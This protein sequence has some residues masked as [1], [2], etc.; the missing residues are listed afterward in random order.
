[1]RWEE[2]Q[3]EGEVGRGEDRQSFDKDVGGGLVAGQVRVELV[4]KDG[5][6]CVSVYSQEIEDAL[7]HEFLLSRENVR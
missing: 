1:M 6:Y 2:V 7:M 4:S 5:G 3:A